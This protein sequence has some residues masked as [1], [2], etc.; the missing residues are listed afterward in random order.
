MDNQLL[1]R[2]YTYSLRSTRFQNYNLFNLQSF[3]QKSTDIEGSGANFSRTSNAA[4]RPLAAIQA[5]K[6]ATK[7]IGDF[8]AAL[9]RELV[10]PQNDHFDSGAFG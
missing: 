6:K 4:C 10:R 3:S 1:P 9:R 5:K 8:G 2:L 7:V